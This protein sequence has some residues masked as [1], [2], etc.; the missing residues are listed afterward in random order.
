MGARGEAV[1]RAGGQD[2]QVL[3][4]NRAIL[5][6]E[7]QLGKGILQVLQDFQ[8]GGSYTDLVA[9]LR[10]GMEAARL[11]ARSG[12]K[13]VSNDNA[14]DV[15]DEVGFAGAVGPVMEALAAV[16]SYGA[17]DEEAPDPNE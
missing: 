2:V 17:G 1:I 8:A 11:D 9:L 6:A 7:K 13:P 14:L 4:T 15:L 16:V 12:G 10:A 3:F 5:S